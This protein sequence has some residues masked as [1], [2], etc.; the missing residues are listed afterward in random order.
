MRAI[1]LWQPWASAIAL[2]LKTYETRHWATSPKPCLAIHA[3]KR[4]T[5]DERHFSAVM[6][7]VHDT[8]ALEAPP[9]GAVVA[10]CDLTA[11]L[12]T[13]DVR[14]KLSARELDFGNYGEGRFAWQL[15][16]IV[17]LKEPVPYTGRQGFFEIDDDTSARILDMAAAAAT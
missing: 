9:L 3:A 5:G 12:R 11:C 17:A 10:V 4:W 6:A 14:N 16:N 8:P 13:E 2:G 7:Q 1:S 15:T